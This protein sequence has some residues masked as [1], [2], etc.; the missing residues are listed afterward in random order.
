MDLSKEIRK[1]PESLQKYVAGQT[2]LPRCFARVE[3]FQHRQNFLFREFYIVDHVQRF[4][5]LLS[6][7]CMMCPVSTLAVFGNKMFHHLVEC[8]LYVS[9]VNVVSDLES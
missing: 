1:A 4:H 5:R 7:A 6:D 9:C 3:L 8:A 2:I